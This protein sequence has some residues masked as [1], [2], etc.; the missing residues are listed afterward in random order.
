MNEVATKGR[1]RRGD[2]AILCA[3]VLCALPGCGSGDS[4]LSVGG[5]PS[6][7]TISGSPVAQVAVGQMYSFTP[8]VQNSGREPAS[9]SIQNKP[10]WMSFSIATGQLTGTPTSA[11]VGTYSN[12][13][14]S[15]SNGTATTSLP[16]FTIAVSQRGTGMATL[17][18]AAPTTNT[19]GTPLTD[20]AGYTIEYGTSSGALDQSVTIASPSDDDLH[21]L[22]SDHRHLV[23][24]RCGLYYRRLTEHAVEYCEHDNKLKISRRALLGG[25]RD[26]RCG[27]CAHA[28]VD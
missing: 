25:R 9:F 6:A 11:D 5:G 27:P 8:T 19:D 17:S 21:D 2:T 3:L 26:P 10:A 20:L 7:P 28:H 15:V 22:G 4:P 1:T 24:R 23:L 12:V 13:V 14:I 16:P 18:W